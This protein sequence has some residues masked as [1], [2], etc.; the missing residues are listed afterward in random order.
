MSVKPSCC[1]AYCA[2]MLPGIHRAARYVETCDACS[3][4]WETFNEL[5]GAVL[6]SAGGGHSRARGPLLL[7]PLTQHVLMSSEL[8]GD[9]PATTA[10]PGVA[11]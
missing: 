5:T 9:L 1:V 4:E 8:T 6:V 10:L 3:K 7:A 2:T 11:P